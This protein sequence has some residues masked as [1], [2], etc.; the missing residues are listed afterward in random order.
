MR[1][2]AA[3]VCRKCMHSSQVKLAAPAIAGPCWLSTAAVACLWLGVARARACW[4][5]VS[6]CLASRHIQHSTVL[7]VLYIHDVHAVDRTGSSPSLPR[8]PSRP[9]SACRGREGRG[10]PGPDRGRT[11]SERHAPTTQRNDSAAPP[12][13][14]RTCARVERVQRDRGGPRRAGTRNPPPSLTLRRETLLF[15][16]E[17]LLEREVS[18]TVDSLRLQM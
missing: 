18:C 8:P 14:G 2:A 15:C 16:C 3:R 10:A 17:A 13:L 12:P 11:C 9:I 7:W 4:A 6:L 1:P 5:P